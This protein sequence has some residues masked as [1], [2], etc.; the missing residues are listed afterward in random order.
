MRKI[1]VLLL[2]FAGFTK[3]NAQ[4]A[5]SICTA[6]IK[7]LDAA[8]KNMLK[9]LH[10]ALMEEKT[11]TSLFNVK[12]YESTITLPGFTQTEIYDISNNG[13][14]AFSTQVEVDDVTAAK[15]M[16]EE[17]RKK[18]QAC[19]KATKQKFVLT[20]NGEKYQLWWQY[21]EAKIA[22]YYHKNSGN[23]RQVFIIE[24]ENQKP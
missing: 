22:L 9:N 7:L 6:L 12:Y 17:W 2:L 20:D 3:A 10:G 14:D 24:I 21:K 5:D 8:D 1:V 18:I 15:K 23:S 19:L 16:R 11:K 4:V 13:N